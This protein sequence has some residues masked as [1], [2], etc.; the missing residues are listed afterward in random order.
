LSLTGLEGL[1]VVKALLE[2]LNEWEL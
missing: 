2:N 1:E